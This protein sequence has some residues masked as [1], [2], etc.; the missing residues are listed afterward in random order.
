MRI[1]FGI[2]F[3]LSLWAE[4]KHQLKV[5]PETVVV[6]FYDPRSKPALRVASGDTGHG[7]TNA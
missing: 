4:T 2:L 6:G 1:A 7:P 3:G 5:T